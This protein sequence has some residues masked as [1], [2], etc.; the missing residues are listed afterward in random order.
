MYCSLHEALLDQASETNDLRP[1]NG[2]WDRLPVELI[3][4]I[5]HEMSAEEIARLSG[6][7]CA[8]V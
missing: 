1:L 8:R 6:V 2:G 3:A 4:K 7:S 5:F